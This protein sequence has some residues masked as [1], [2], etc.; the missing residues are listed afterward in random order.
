MP[1]FGLDKNVTQSEAYKVMPDDELFFVQEVRVDIPDHD[2]PGQ[3]VS[4][5]VCTVCNEGINDRREV[6][7]NGYVLCRAC[8]QGGYYQELK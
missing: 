8:S 1:P 6:R 7:L 5:V 3:P 4:H 2:R